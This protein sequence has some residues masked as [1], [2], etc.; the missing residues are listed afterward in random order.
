MRRAA[1]LKAQQSELANSRQQMAPPD[2]LQPRCRDSGDRGPDCA[3][4]STRSG[5]LYGQA[6]PRRGLAGRILTPA[7]WL[8]W[9]A[10]CWRACGAIPSRL[11]AD[12]HAAGMAPSPPGPQRACSASPPPR[13]KASAPI[14]PQGQRPGRGW[15]AGVAPRRKPGGSRGGGLLAA[16]GGVLRPHLPPPGRCH[17]DASAN[18]AAATGSLAGPPAESTIQS[19]RPHSISCNMPGPCQHRILGLPACAYG[20]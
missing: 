20:S 2:V 13:T 18:P 19:T 4:R 14:A 12:A 17:A 16:A 9:A 7:S 1:A 5:T 8:P 11:A 10:E 15:W 3:R 6:R